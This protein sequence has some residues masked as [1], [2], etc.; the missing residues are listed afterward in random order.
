M[1]SCGRW[2]MGILGKEKKGGEKDLGT[3]QYQQ[4]DF[5]R[6]FADDIVKVEAHAKQKTNRY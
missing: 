4:L 5:P 2:T 6:I 1:L 3:Q